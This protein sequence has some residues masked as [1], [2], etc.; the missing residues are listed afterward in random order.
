MLTWVFADIAS[1]ACPAHPGCLATLFRTFA[2]VIC[3]VENHLF[4]ENSMRTR[5]VCHHV[6]S[7]HSTT[8]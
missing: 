8:W 1:L 2:A 4:R 6:T 7:E 3:D 5:V